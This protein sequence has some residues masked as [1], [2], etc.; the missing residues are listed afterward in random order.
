M[1][2]SGGANNLLEKQ[3]NSLILPKDI[4]TKSLKSGSASTGSYLNTLVDLY[5][6]TCSECL[7]PFSALPNHGLHHD[8]KSLI[9]GI[10]KPP[11]EPDSNIYTFPLLY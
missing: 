9:Y 1:H 6:N 8:C 2:R 3:V 5:S 10:P 4:G 7:K 11:K